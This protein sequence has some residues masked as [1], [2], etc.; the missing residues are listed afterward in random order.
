MN[1][2]RLEIWIKGSLNPPLGRLCIVNNAMDDD[3]MEVIAPNGSR[4]RDHGAVF[5]EIQ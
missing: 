5:E 3:L 1:V 2:S 4:H